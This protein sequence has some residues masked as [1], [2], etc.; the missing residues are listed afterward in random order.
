MATRDLD[1]NG[2]LTGYSRVIEKTMRAVCKRD[3]RSK[4]NEVKEMKVGV[5][6][7][8]RWPESKGVR[9]RDWRQY[10]GSAEILEVIY[11]PYLKSGGICK[12]IKSKR[13][14]SNIEIKCN[15]SPQEM[16]W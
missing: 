4:S 12:N 14:D 1:E 16:E 11:C 3:I 8:I 7:R 15:P 2:R 9:E 5:K 10:F 6:I 13:F